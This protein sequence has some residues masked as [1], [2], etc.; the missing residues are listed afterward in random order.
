MMLDQI[1]I[2]SSMVDK[3]LQHGNITAI[4]KTLNEG[5]MKAV[6]LDFMDLVWKAA[7]SLAK[8]ALI[9]AVLMKHRP[10]LIAAGIVSAAL[11]VTAIRLYE[12]LV[13]NGKIDST[14]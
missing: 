5:E 3:V 2:I 8:S 10:T 13:L 14:K 4:D 1:E 12:R 6:V 7:R 9:D 11:E